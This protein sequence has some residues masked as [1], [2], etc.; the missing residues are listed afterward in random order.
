MPVVKAIEGT[1]TGAADRPIQ[2]VR[3][4]SCGVNSRAGVQD[5]LATTEGGAAGVDPASTA[6]G[7]SAAPAAHN[8]EGTGA[9]VDHSG[10]PLNDA[11]REGQGHH[12]G[13]PAAGGAGAAG[14][15]GLAAHHNQQHQQ[16]QQFN[17][18]GAGGAGVGT[19]LGTG[20]GGGETYHDALDTHQPL[21]STTTRSTVVG[22]PGPGPSPGYGD[23]SALDSMRSRHDPL[24]PRSGTGYGGGSDLGSALSTTSTTGYAGGAGVS[25]TT[26]KK[27]PEKRRAS[28][29]ASAA[30]DF[31]AP[32]LRDNVQGDVNARSPESSAPIHQA[33]HGGGGWKGAASGLYRR[34]SKSDEKE[35]GKVPASP[36][37][38]SARQPA[39]GSA[40]VDYAGTHPVDHRREGVDGQ[41][42]TTPAIHRAGGA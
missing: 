21:H 13:I 36:T 23:G 29:F 19:G 5:E 16:N 25:P 28:A 31:A 4:V 11:E 27:P 8:F 17:Q 41:L 7:T 30:V 12:G 37:S 39:L 15:A 3:I 33:H 18:H 40:G 14:A 9:P 22:G 38:P 20:T 6:T 24:D 42:E 1:P 10:A 34:F 26:S 32:N 2:T 35:K